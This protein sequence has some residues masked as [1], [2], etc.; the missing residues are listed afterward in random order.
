MGSTDAIDSFLPA[1]AKAFV[2]YFGDK[3]MQSLLVSGSDDDVQ[4]VIRKCPLAALKILVVSSVAS[5]TIS[6][7]MRD[8]GLGKLGDT[9]VEVLAALAP[10]RDRIATSLRA[11]G[12]P[13]LARDEEMT[14]EVAATPLLNLGDGGIEVRWEIAS[15]GE[16]K[17]ESTDHPA[18]LL[19]AFTVVGKAIQD[20]WRAAMQM[21]W[22]LTEEAGQSYTDLLS[23]CAQ[24][25]DGLASVLREAEE[26]RKRKRTGD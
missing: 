4:E 13:L 2:S 21:G 7:L 24:T 19:Y 1:A 20:G 11:E 22:V 10:A 5:S 3:D 8:E 15:N 16:A 25:I 9:V 17:V 6:E 14:A 18:A 26:D 23:Q 12:F